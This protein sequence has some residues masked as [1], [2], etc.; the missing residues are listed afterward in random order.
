MLTGVD[1]WA[2]LC[3]PSPVSAIRTPILPL[4]PLWEKGVGGMRGTGASERPPFPFSPLWEKGEGGDEGANIHLRSL[5]R[6]T[7]QRSR[8]YPRSLHQQRCQR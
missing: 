4:L 5:R 8:H 6:K 2:G 7:Q 1:V 3:V